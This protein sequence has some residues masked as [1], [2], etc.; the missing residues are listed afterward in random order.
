MLRM[1]KREPSLIRFFFFPFC[2]WKV[3][4]FVS[5]LLLAYRSVCWRTGGGKFG[6]SYSLP[7]MFIIFPLSATK[8]G[9]D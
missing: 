4:E 5:A 8:D 2:A 3:P 9:K 1:K 6:V 7:F